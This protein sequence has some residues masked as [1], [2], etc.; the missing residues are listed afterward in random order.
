[1]FKKPSKKQFLIRRILLSVL[2]TFSVIIIATVTI[3]FLLGY[4]LDSGNGRLEQGAL[5][6]FDSTPS[7]A[8][9]YLDG[10][11]IGVR[12]AGKHTVIAGERT[13]KMVKYGYQDWTRTL[14]IKAGTLTWLDYARLVPV[15]RPLTSV[16]SYATLASA[17]IS[18]DG[19]WALLQEDAGA[20][21]FHL[22][23]LRSE[24]VKSTHL[25]LPQAQYGDAATAGVVH[26]FSPVSWDSGGR[27][28]LLSHHFDSQVEW[29]VL[30]TQ[31][32]NN[33]KNITRIFNTSFKDIKFASTNGRVLYGLTDDGTLR[34]INLSHE[35]LSR[36]IVSHVESFDVFDN[37]IVS[38]V[39]LHPQDATKRV[40]GV[41]RDGDE[42]S[43]V[44]RTVN[45]TDI[46]LRIAVGRYFSDDYVAIAQ[47]GI[48]TV[49]KGKYPS[50]SSQ[51]AS[52]LN[53][54]AIFELDGV[55]SALSIS[56]KGNYVLAQSG[57]TFKS[58]EIEHTRTA[59]GTIATVN[60]DTPASPLKWLDIAHMWNDDNGTLIMRD[61][62]GSNTYPIMAVAPGFDASLSQNGRFFYGVG[63][64][65]DMY[66]FQRVKMILD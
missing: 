27:Y 12:T 43:H 62:D 64:K 31:D 22:L 10:V 46:T 1:M 24:T 59:T 56:S 4:R 21:N 30:D 32:A 18:P 8:D 26:S 14:T 7:G 11:P 50:S 17:K 49:L 23:D 36:A 47:D 58:Y 2:A 54:F 16:A 53:Q 60:N 5:L 6:Q 65:D 3:L 19:K 39:G 41:Y 35:T 61:F 38:Y 42:S 9:V 45:S 51:D 63:K 44:L 40:A 25:M 34:N 52:S 20:P 57:T 28:I 37:T 13:V 55:V 48:V 33:V 15:D 66:Q 29:L